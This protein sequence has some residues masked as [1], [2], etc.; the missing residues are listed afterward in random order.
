MLDHEEFAQ[1][2][3]AR[4]IDSFLHDLFDLTNQ[5]T[6]VSVFQQPKISVR[7]LQAVTEFLFRMNKYS[8]QFS[9]GW[10][11]EVGNKKCWI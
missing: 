5:L 9:M 6:N 2:I 11:E 3:E 8:K 4:G 10:E 7:I 1:P